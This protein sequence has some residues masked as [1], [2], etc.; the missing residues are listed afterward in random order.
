MNSRIIEKLTCI[1]TDKDM[2]DGQPMYKTLLKMAQESN[3]LQVTATKGLAMTNATLSFRNSNALQKQEQPIFVQTLGTQD[4]NERFLK[5]IT[6]II[7]GH[8]ITK[9]QIEVI[10]SRA[11]Q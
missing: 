10:S 8:I 5:K 9:E 11:I 2:Y 4:E 1:T 7:Q 6:P 3:L